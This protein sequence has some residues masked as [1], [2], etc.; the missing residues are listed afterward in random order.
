MIDTKRHV[1]LRADLSSSMVSC[2]RPDPRILDATVPLDTGASRGS[3]GRSGCSWP[4]V[5]VLSIL[6][7]SAK[8]VRV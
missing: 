6:T 8:A 3:D 1:S 4:M 7:L 5:L 2:H